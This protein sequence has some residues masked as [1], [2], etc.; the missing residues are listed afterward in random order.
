MNERLI[1]QYRLTSELERSEGHAVYLAEDTLKHRMV[2]LHELKLDPTDGPD[3]LDTARQSLIREAKLTMEL[4]HPNV[5]RVE[6]LI[7]REDECFVVCEWVEG[8]RTLREALRSGSMAPERAVAIAL[9]ALDAL[10]HAHEHRIVHRNVRPEHLLLFEGGVK[11]TSFAM[12]K[13][14]DLATRSSFDLRQMIAENPYAAPEF[15]LGQSAHHK[16]D[17][18]A[19]VFAAGAVLYEMLTGKPPSHVDEKVWEAPSRFNSAVG[20]ALD[21]AIA[22]SLRFDPAQ[23]L[24]S[25]ASFKARLLEAMGGAKANPT[26]HGSRYVERRLL[27]RTR[28]SLIFQAQDAHLDRPVALKKVLLEPSFTPSE[29]QAAL[30]SRMQEERAA[31]SLVHPH[32]IAILDQFV[33]DED[34]YLVT[35]WLEGS[36]LREV[37][38]GKRQSLSHDEIL[39][40]IRQVGEAIA[41]AHHHG[42]IHRDLKPENLMLHQGHVTVLDF[43]LAG[44]FDPSMMK[45]G[46]TARYLAPEAIKGE[47]ANFQSDVYSLAVVAYEL[48]TGTYPYRPE[49]LMAGF[50]TGELIEN[51]VPPSQLRLEVTADVDV[52]LLKALA[53]HPSERYGAMT[54]F[55]DALNRAVEDPVEVADEVPWKALILTAVGALLLAALVLGGFFASPIIRTWLDPLPAP[56]PVVSPDAELTEYPEHLDDVQP[57]EPVQPLV[58]PRPDPTPEPVTTAP[59]A[60]SKALMWASRPSTRDGVTL[61]VTSIRIE[62]DQT[63]VRIRVANDSPEAISFLGRN[64]QPDLVSVSDDEGG[65]YSAS[66]D[67][68]SVSAG[69]VRIEA[70]SIS[71]GS[72]ILNERISPTANLVTVSLREYAGA[73]RHFILRAHRILDKP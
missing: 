17:A 13:K 28:N 45:T 32:I 57:T 50:A 16:V 70:G 4:D 29:R 61:E 33:E 69:L 60:P 72:F 58:T 5:L 73:E 34:P 66:L 27:R 26:D 30:R 42:V 67:M 8:A 22:R 19:D 35:E 21:E 6:H 44:P 63:L 1:N 64:D 47:P 55:L 59:P 56:A 46:G 53:V 39:G 20:P 41:Y 62:G 54:D 65:D 36:D 71:D 48:L 24:P 2:L 68:L 15:R 23:R 49:A 18:R 37:L 52:V 9:A 25:A 10:H 7:P 14:S 40:V 11:L 51:P 3:A 43:G 38:D 12:A 31:S